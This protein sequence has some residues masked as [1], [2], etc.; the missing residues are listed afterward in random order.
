MGSMTQVVAA[1]FLLGGQPN[2]MVVDFSATYCGPCQEMSPIVE[3]LKRQGY[4]I[5]KVDIQERPDLKKRFNISSIPTFVLIIDGKE[6]QRVEGKMSEQQLRRMAMQ[7]PTKTTQT[8]VASTNSAMSRKT[9]TMFVAQNTSGLERARLGSSANFDDYLPAPP[10]M[11]ARANISNEAPS[12]VAPAARKIASQFATTARLRVQEGQGINFGTG[13]VIESVVGRTL[14]LTCGHV[15]RGVDEKSKIEVDLFAHGDSRTYVGTVVDFDLDA[16][17][18]LVSVPT[19]DPV[20]TSKVASADVAMAVNDRVFSIGCSGGADPTRDDIAITAL[21]RYKGPDNIECSGQPV[22]GRSGGGLFDTEGNVVG[23]CI[24]VDQ[25]EG[26]GLYCGLKPIHTLLKKNGFQHLLGEPEEEVIPET[27]IFAESQ[28]VEDDTPE[29]SRIG[30]RNLMADGNVVPISAE[31]HAGTNAG[32]SPAQLSPEQIQ[33]LQQTLAQAGGAKL[34]I[35]IESP[36]R[37]HQTQVVIVPAASQKLIADLTGAVGGGTGVEASN[38]RL[39]SVRKQLS[40]T[41]QQVPQTSY[42]M[43]ASPFPSVYQSPFTGQSI[44]SGHFRHSTPRR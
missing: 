5:Q 10:K 43:M 9:A 18:G 44:V 16:D 32:H 42:K 25:E 21:N 15:L 40:A 39:T 26:R 24:A 4:A 20:I 6:V 36:E 33:R 7:I 22:P 30:N 12:P 19:S 41:Q 31:I 38:M 23:V 3:K 11:V 35:I 17:V 29:A 14:I 34:T 1:M 2:G 27:R 13:T 8:V 28:P 37:P